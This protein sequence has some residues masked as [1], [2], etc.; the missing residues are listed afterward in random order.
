[1]RELIGHT[2]AAIKAM[3][4]AV[5]AA[6]DT[7]EPTAWTHVQLGKLYFNHGRYAEGAHEY[8]LGN[9]AFPNYAYGLDAL[10][11][12]EAAL[13]RYSRAIA[14]ERQGVD[15]I[16]L[17]QYVGAFGDLYRV[18]GHPP[19]ARRHYAWTGPSARLPRANA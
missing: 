8:A 11:Q 1:G 14:P 3:K 7:T 15:L 13:G 5:D 17:P 9:A 16:P 2:A 10:A 6:T 12:A 4:L 18:T 19:L